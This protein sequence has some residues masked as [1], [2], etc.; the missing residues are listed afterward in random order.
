MSKTIPAAYTLHALGDYQAL[1]QILGTNY[2]DVIRNQ[3]RIF[4]DIGFDLPGPTAVTTTTLD[5]W[6]Q[7]GDLD[8]I[9][10]MIR[11]H[12]YLDDAGAEVSITLEAFLGGDSEVRLIVRDIE[13]QINR[14]TVTCINNASTPAW[15]TASGTISEANATEVSGR[16]I[17]LYCYWEMR[18]QTAG[19]TATLYQAH[20]L[21][22]L[23]RPG[24][25]LLLP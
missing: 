18:S 24:D 9:A 7:A 22:T 12:R 16:P 4:A 19:V 6:T 15:I 2:L 14:L 10:G 21:E 23:L 5:T 13:A 11:S 17:P 1:Q 25:E 3:N 20:A 8:K